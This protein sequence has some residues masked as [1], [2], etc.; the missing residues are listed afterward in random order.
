MSWSSITTWLLF[1]LAPLAAS[2]A[3][4]TTRQMFRDRCFTLAAIKT[5]TP[6]FKALIAD[7]DSHQLKAYLLAEG[8]YL[9]GTQVL[10]H[11]FYPKTPYLGTVEGFRIE[12][13][14]ISI[15]IRSETGPTRFW[16]EDGM[17]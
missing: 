4:A 7:M 12:L 14:H 6:G 5:S 16:V 11:G 9:N 15:E 10:I 2:G 13:G 8:A 17:E 1:P 3:Q